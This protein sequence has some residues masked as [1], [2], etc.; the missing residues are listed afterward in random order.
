MDRFV[1]VVR[2][3]FV[4]KLGNQGKVLINNLKA[5]VLFS[6]LTCDRCFAQL[7]STALQE[8]NPGLCRK[9]CILIEDNYYLVAKLD[10][11]VL[12]LTARRKKQR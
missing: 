2:M 7:F 9:L 10:K 8:H 6:N 5:E 11:Q 3:C 4:S 1:V 12:Q